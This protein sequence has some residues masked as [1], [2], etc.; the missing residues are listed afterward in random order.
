MRFTAFIALLLLALPC[1]VQAA[2]QSDRSGTGLQ[3]HDHIH[4]GQLRGAPPSAM[5]AEPAPEPVPVPVAPPRPSRSE[6]ERMLVNLSLI[7]I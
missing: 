1:S 7:H 5:R 6:Q 4:Q 2:R 3:G